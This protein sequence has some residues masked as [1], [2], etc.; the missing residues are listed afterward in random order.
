MWVQVPLLSSSNDYIWAYWGSAS[1]T[2]QQAYTT[3]GATWSEGYAGVWH[4][5][6]GNGT[7]TMDSK[8][9]H[10]G[11][12][13]NVVWTNAQIAR[14]VSFDGSSYIGTG[15][16]GVT[17]GITVES[18]VYSANFSQNG[19]IVGKNPVNARWELF[20][21]G[22]NLK[23]RGADSGNNVA[24]AGPA[25]GQWHHVSGA[26]TNTTGFLYI[27]GVYRTQGAATQIGAAS[28]DVEFGRFASGYYY[29]GVMD[30]VRVSSVSRSSNWVWACW[31]NMGSNSVFT[32]YGAATFAALPFIETFEERTSGILH[33]QNGW[34]TSP[35][36]GVEVQT[37]VV[38]A[39]SKAG[40]MV[41]NSSLEHDFGD[42]G[43]TN[44]WLDL[45][46]RPA[47]RSVAP[48]IGDGP[49]AIFYVNKNGYINALSNSTWVN[50]SNYQ[51]SS[52]QWYRF[53]IYLDYGASRWEL[54]VADNVPN[55]LATMLSTNLSF[56]AG[57]TNVAFKKFKV[58]N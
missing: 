30:E 48:T 3:N 4:F 39:G 25:N 50:F 57:A 7:S 55:R 42:T 41:T 9:G 11:T 6:E 34:V 5:P 21:E 16:W 52:N 40:Q 2:N 10:D 32:T 37:S 15:D 12:L 13:N 47:F 43:V 53:T 36:G 27:D 26:Q 33:G 56:A 1:Q 23:W 44:M 19:F 51:L 14:G 29:V 8:R 46:A 18:W 58:M 38:Y 17:N 35:V 45:C 22:A 24:T 54:Y 49:S 28:G 20:F 31:M